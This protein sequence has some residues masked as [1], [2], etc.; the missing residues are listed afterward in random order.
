MRLHIWPTWCE[1]T[2]G[3]ATS[4]RANLLL[5]SPPPLRTVRDSVAVFVCRL[6]SNRLSAAGLRLLADALGHNTAL[7]EIW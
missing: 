4:G 1:Q 2:L 3:Y 7:Q 6:I 5:A